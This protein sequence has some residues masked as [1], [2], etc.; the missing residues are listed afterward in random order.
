M[1]A[2]EY[3]LKIGAN[4]PSVIFAIHPEPGMVTH[5]WVHPHQPGDP[6][7]SDGDSWKADWYK[8][9]WYKVPCPQTWADDEVTWIFLSESLFGEYPTSA[10]LQL[11]FHFITRRAKADQL[12]GLGFILDHSGKIVKRLPPPDMSRD[13][14]REN[15]DAPKPYD[16]ELLDWTELHPPCGEPISQAS[17]RPAKLE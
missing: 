5:K 3:G 13:Y 17:S 14:L 15:H 12:Y 11:S 4:H 2:S 7:R 10:Y 9:E 1:D 8:P 16:L 6:P